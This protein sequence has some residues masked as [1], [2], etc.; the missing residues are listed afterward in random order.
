MDAN[1][2]TRMNAL[3]LPTSTSTTLSSS[4]PPISSPSMKLTFQITCRV[5][6]ICL[7]SLIPDPSLRYCSRDLVSAP[8][9]RGGLQ[10]RIVSSR[11]RS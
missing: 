4:S 1:S 10:R 3:Y 6:S 8:V 9:E 7:I 2:I 11:L 5:P